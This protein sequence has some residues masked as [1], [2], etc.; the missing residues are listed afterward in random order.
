M[1]A[2]KRGKSR[3]ERA[4]PMSDLDHRLALREQATGTGLPDACEI[5][6]R[7]REQK[8]LWCADFL[9]EY[10][11]RAKQKT[12]GGYCTAS[13]EGTRAKAWALPEGW[14]L[15]ARGWGAPHGDDPNDRWG[16]GRG[17]LVSPEGFKAWA[18][19]DV[20]K[21]RWTLRPLWEKTGNE[22]HNPTRYGEKCPSVTFAASRGEAGLVSA[23]KRL[24]KQSQELWETSRAYK[25]EHE[26]REVSRGTAADALREIG[27]EVGQLSSI[28]QEDSVGVPMGDCAGGSYCFKGRLSADGS[29]VDL[30]LRGLSLEQVRAIYAVLTG[31]AGQP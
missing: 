22:T 30:D 23:L 9:S 6:R 28:G 13:L 21:L 1:G 8:C 18:F 26:A 15:G 12:C 24:V 25:Q 3:R 31:K 14:T 17:E 29:K 19:L 20:D 2:A 11:V 27:F 7:E 4:L 10:R 5:R 16:L